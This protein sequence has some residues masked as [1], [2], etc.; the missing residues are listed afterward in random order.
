MH[1]CSFF[2]GC[3]MLIKAACIF[4]VLRVYGTIHDNV[5]FR[6]VS[7]NIDNNTDQLIPDSERY[8]S[9]YF[10]ILSWLVWG[11]ENNWPCKVNLK[12]IYLFPMIGHTFKGNLESSTNTFRAFLSNTSIMIKHNLYYRRPIILKI[13]LSVKIV[14]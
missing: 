13:Q 10:I 1:N 14:F 11:K 6:L 2:V 12:C 5:L 3:W 9:S 4:F 8:L 7:S